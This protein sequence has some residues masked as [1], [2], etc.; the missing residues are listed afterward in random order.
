MSD[1][2]Q[3]IVEI[4][5]DPGWHLDRLGQMKI[6]A[7]NIADRVSKI[8]TGILDGKWEGRSAAVA[9]AHL[10]AM[11]LTLENAQNW[12]VQVEDAISRHNREVADFASDELEKLPTGDLPSAVRDA[13]DRGKPQAITQ[14]GLISLGTGPAGLA[15][16]NQFFGNMRQKAAEDA[17]ERVAAYVDDKAAELRGD[18][19][20]GFDRVKPNLPPDSTPNDGENEPEGPDSN[21]GGG[22][23]GTS[24]TPPGV[25]G[26]PSVGG[27]GGGTGGGIGGPDGHGPS[28]THDPPGTRDPN[29]VG[30]PGT[31]DPNWPNDP[32]Y[33]PPYD[34]NRPDGPG[35]NSGVDPEWNDPGRRPSV[36]SNLDGST[37]R[38]GLGAAGLGA[39]GLA[40]GAKLAGAGGNGSGLGLG[41]AGQ[42]VFGVG[43]AG[44]AG[45]AGLGGSGGLR[46]AASAAPSGSGSAAGSSNSSG[47]A[48]GG[49]PGAMMGGGGGGGGTEKK[50]A[51]SGLGYI[52][53]KLEDEGDGGPAARAS[54]AGGRVPE[55]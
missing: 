35:S 23:P 13:I 4:A 19:L 16:A 34:P 46:G 52:A 24:V 31:R 54:R 48:R 8:E 32:P 29:V 38:S 55:E 45:G 30:D 49:R 18:V 53:P 15:I 33:D 37:L 2:E 27:P 10:T 9:A 44:G 12:L 41:G 3:Q 39:A 14:Y 40:A 43:G 5:S 51:R 6:A 42:G 47:G 11:R 7:K 25:G 17:H 1:I 20:V 21:I 28:V 22:G 36:D 50:S 26:P